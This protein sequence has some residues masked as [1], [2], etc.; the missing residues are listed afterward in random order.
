MKHVLRSVIA[1]TMALLVI[2]SGTMSVSATDVTTEVEV[3]GNTATTYSNT[4]PHPFGS[5]PLSTDTSWKTIAYSNTGFSCNVY[6]A[7][8]NTATVGISVVPSDVRML[9]K[10]GQ[11]V[12][13]ASGYIPGLGH[14]ILWCGSDVYTLQIRTQAGKGTAYA[15]Q[16]NEDPV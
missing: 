6:V 4:F 7:C 8:Y 14:R 11:V 10:N 1:W 9:G 16:T 3:A 5:N 13:S 15:Y 12:W 2:F